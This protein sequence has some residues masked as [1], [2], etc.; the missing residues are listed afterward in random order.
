[1][2]AAFIALFAGHHVGDHW[3]Q[4]DHQAQTKGR[5]D[6]VGRR[7]CA[8]HTA[9][10]TLCQA[11]AL[12]VVA[13]YGGA[14][15]APLNLVIGLAVNALSHYW[16]DRRSTLEGLAYALHRTGKH[17]YYRVGSAQLDQ[18]FHMAFLLLS[19][20]IVA[21]GDTVALV[22]STALALGVLGACAALSRL[23]RGLQPGIDA[24]ELES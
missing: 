2:S 14:A 5:H 3:A 17:N 10:L 11:A 23:G 20:V 13:L 19:A 12:A 7:A 1:M 15:F 16:C 9:T 18:A 6:R 21:A 8:A 24:R 22:G 4:T